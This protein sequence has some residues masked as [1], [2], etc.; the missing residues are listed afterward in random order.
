MSDNTPFSLQQLYE[1]ICSRRTASPESSYTASLFAQGEAKISQKVGEE[2]T[3]VIVA[4]LAQ[5]R[6]RLIEE[7]SDLFYH[8]LVL[9][10]AKGITLDEVTAELASRHR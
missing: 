10:A 5:S 7:S 4:A 2:A 6:E 8:T 1:I 3:E 9:L